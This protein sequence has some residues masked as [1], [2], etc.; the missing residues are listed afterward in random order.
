MDIPSKIDKFILILLKFVV[1]IT[2]MEK[3]I[4]TGLIFF[5]YFFVKSVISLI[6][7]NK[8]EPNE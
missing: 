3:N 6:E 4:L 7:S 5:L 1:G 2:L 8:A